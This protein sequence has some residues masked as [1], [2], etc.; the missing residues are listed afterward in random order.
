[1]EQGNKAFNE[2]RA[3]LG[4]LD[5]SIDEARSRRLGPPAQSDS[6]NTGSNPSDSSDF[7]L[8][9]EIGGSSEK[10]Q[11]ELQK[12]GAQFGRA[13]PLNRENNS[14]WKSTSDNNPDDIQIG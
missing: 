8:D 11:T 5:R 4:K 12:R 3:L 2:V 10:T 7:D 1:M 14:L 9:Q 13:K 6:P